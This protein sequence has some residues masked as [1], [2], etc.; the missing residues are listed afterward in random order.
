MIL[1]CVCNFLII[2]DY[3]LPLML[4][5]GRGGRRTM[6]RSERKLLIIKGRKKKEIK[7]QRVR[8]IVEA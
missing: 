1:Y 4:M 5:V 6:K 3:E 8:Q 7:I 2:I